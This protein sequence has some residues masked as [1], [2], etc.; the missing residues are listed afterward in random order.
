MPAKKFDVKV[1]NATM[2]AIGR[3]IYPFT[4]A[5]ITNTSRSV[6]MMK[7]RYASDDRKIQV[8]VPGHIL[9]KVNTHDAQVQA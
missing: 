5:S 1:W 3:S 7:F 2:N 6:Y 8:V 9:A 4:Q